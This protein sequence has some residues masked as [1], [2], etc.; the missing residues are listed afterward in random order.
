M[1]SSG[2]RPSVTVPVPRSAP[3]HSAFLKCSSC[4]IPATSLPQSPTVWTW[5]DSSLR[6]DRT[7][8]MRGLSP[9]RARKKPG[10]L[11]FTSFTG[12]AY[13]IWVISSRTSVPDMFFA[14]RG[15]VV[16]PYFSAISAAR[17][18]VP[19]PAGSIL[20]TTTTKGF[21]AALAASMACRSASS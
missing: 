1:L 6:R 13:R 15:T 3:S 16:T 7:P 21:D 17:A 5:G 10:T 2:V 20:F 11:I 4:C 14:S 12:K 18:W 19:S 9:D 8:S